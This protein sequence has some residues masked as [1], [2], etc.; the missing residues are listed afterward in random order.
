MATK[1]IVFISKGFEMSETRDRK[2]HNARKPTNS[3]R[4]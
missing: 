2:G 4:C 1:E 3:L